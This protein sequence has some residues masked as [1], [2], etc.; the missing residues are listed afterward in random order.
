MQPCTMASIV[1]PVYALLS[2]YAAY[3]PVASESVKLETASES[4]A[5]RLPSPCVT[6]VPLANQP[7]QSFWCVDA[8]PV[9][10]NSNVSVDTSLGLAVGVALGD[11]VGAV[12]LNV[13]TALGLAVGLVVGLDV[14]DTVRL[15][16][17]PM[18][19]SLL[20]Q[21]AVHT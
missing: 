8:E 21:P 11:N 20:L 6:V 14:G 12:G 10:S 17:C 15:H 3:F 9:P 5:A 16:V 7:A 19:A 1:L 4:Y 2:V 13:G 18:C